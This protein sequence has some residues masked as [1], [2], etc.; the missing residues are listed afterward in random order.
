MSPSFMLVL[1]LVL[2]NAVIAVVRRALM[3]P[4][5]QYPTRRSRPDSERNVQ[6]L[7]REAQMF[8]QLGIVLLTLIGAGSCSTAR[9]TKM[10]ARGQSGPDDIGRKLISAGEQNSIDAIKALLPTHEE[11]DAALLCSERDVAAHREL[12]SLARHIEGFRRETGKQEIKGSPVPPPGS[13]EYLGR[14]ARTDSIEE[15]NVGEIWK[16]CIAQESLTY[17][18]TQFLVRDSRSGKTHH[19]NARLLRTGTGWFLLDLYPRPMTKASP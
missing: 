4:V 3:P 16:G 9:D 14:N 17:L 12:A 1:F 2:S 15:I 10:S 11:L 8:L 13:L 6:I 7:P 18:D 19:Q 5:V